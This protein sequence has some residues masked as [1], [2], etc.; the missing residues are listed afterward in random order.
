MHNGRWYMVWGDMW[1]PA[2]HGEL[3]FSSPHFIDIKSTFYFRCI[4]D[5]YFVSIFLDIKMTKIFVLSIF[6]SILYGSRVNILF[7]WLNIFGFFSKLLNQHVFCCLNISSFCQHLGISSQDCLLLSK[8]FVLFVHV[9]EIWRQHFVLLSTF[10]IDMERTLFQRC[11]ANILS[12]L[13]PHL[14]L[15]I[16][17]FRDIEHFVWYWTNI[18]SC[19]VE[20]SYF[21]QY[22]QRCDGNVINENAF[23]LLPFGFLST[24]LRYIS[25]QI[26]TNVLVQSTI[27]IVLLSLDN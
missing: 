3:F 4:S 19:F 12:F 9:S 24:F 7:C 13:S 23:V 1:W 10:F 25:Q 27:Y 6:L 14:L 18:S 5:F 26:F 2:G 15:W 21:Y 20:M 8:H 17:V 11:W 22:F 16:S